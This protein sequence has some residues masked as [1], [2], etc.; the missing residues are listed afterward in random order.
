MIICPLNN[1]E[2]SKKV[3]P[4]KKTAFIISRSPK[5][6]EDKKLKKVIGEVDSILKK[7]GFKCFYGAD[8]ASIGDY[9]CDICSNILSS[10][11]GVAFSSI[12]TPILSLCNIFMEKGLMHGFGK[13][14]VLFIDH[15]NNL[16]SD[17]KREY[18]IVYKDRDYLKKFIKIIKIFK[19]AQNY[20]HKLG[21]IALKAEDYE[22]AARYYKDAY[23][24][25]AKK[26]NK[27]INNLIFLLRRDNNNSLS[28]KSR[29]LNDLNTFK[30]LSKK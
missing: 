2:C 15:L 29:L 11:F 25:G 28:I 16:P 12:D 19:S 30:V 17:F 4:R 18:I 3:A 10:A 13:P 27:K 5:V 22:R 8:S 21:D 14:V 6:I 24:M 1:D 26:T 23:L 20:Y 9:F 7:N